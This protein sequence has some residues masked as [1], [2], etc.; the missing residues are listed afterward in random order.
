MNRSNY[1][2]SNNMKFSRFDRS[3]DLSRSRDGSSS[4]MERSN[5]K[6]KIFGR[7][8]ESIISQIQPRTHNNYSNMG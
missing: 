1:H 4:R 2:A 5:S 8:D 3:R 7:G 6:K